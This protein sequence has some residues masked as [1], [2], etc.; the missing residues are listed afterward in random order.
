MDYP[1]C[2]ISEL[3]LGKFSDSLEFQSR[4]VNFKTVQIQ[5]SLKTLCTGSKKKSIDDLLTS[6]SIIGR[7]YFPDYEMLD[8]KIASALEKDYHECALLKESTCPR[9]TCSKIR[10]ILTKLTNVFE[11]QKLMKLHKAYQIY[12]VCAKR[13]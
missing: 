12:L 10:P 5:C 11:P 9:A 3:H 13:I 4:E 1:R 7:R 8:A 6:Q 2:P